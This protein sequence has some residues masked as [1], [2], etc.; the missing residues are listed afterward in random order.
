MASELEVWTPAQLDTLRKTY[1]R[2]V[3]DAELALFAQVC[4]HLGLSPFRDEITIVPRRVRGETVWRHQVQVQGRRLLAVRT[5]EL[6]G[7][8]WEWCGPHAPDADSPLRWVDV[9]LEDEPPHA[10]RCTVERERLLDDGTLSRWQVTGT[11]PWRRTR[12][13]WTMRDG[14]RVG[15]WADMPDHMLAKVAESKA[16]RAAFPDVITAEVAGEWDDTDPEYVAPS[17]GT[18]AAE[19]GNTPSPPPPSP[20]PEPEY[21]TKGQGDT[22]GQLL[23]ALGLTERAEVRAY[24]TTILGHEVTNVKRITRAEA[25][26]IIERARADADDLMTGADPEADDAVVVAHG[27]HDERVEGCPLC[28]RGGEPL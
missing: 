6:R 21:M 4:G 16:L 2:G 7:I 15:P 11:W 22:I 17:G 13:F 25:D 5:G 19:V 12:S 3:P 14:E 20:E 27:Y 23:S 26:R 1:L 10:A 28:H 18:V 9:W 24:V 8:T